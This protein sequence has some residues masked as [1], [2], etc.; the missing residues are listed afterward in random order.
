MATSITEV[1]LRFT[2]DPRGAKEALG[3]IRSELSKSAKE[4][5]ATSKQEAQA[6]AAL[7]RQRSAALIQ[8]WRL[9]TRAL[10]SEEK[11]R[12]QESAREERA[13]AS[14]ALSLQRQRSAALIAQW[15]AEQREQVRIARE[16]AREVEAAQSRRGAFV[17]GAIGGVTALVGVSAVNEIRQAGA[18]WL[19]YSSKLQTTKIAFT[20]MLGSAQLAEDHL[21]E[22]QQ[23][24]LKT[25]F[26]FGELIDASQR[27]Q[28]LGFNAQ[29]VVPILT[30]VGNA[31][32]AAGGGSERLDR[33]VLALSQIQSKGKVAT[34]ELNQ[35]AESGIPAFRIL[36]ET[37]GKTG[38]EVRK[39][40]EEG[41]IS[42]KVFLDAFQKFSQQN[43]GGLMEEQS[44]TFS[45]AMSN[46]KDALLQTSATAFAPL[47][48]KL[49]QTAKGFAD[50][51]TSSKDFQEKLKVV[52]SVATTIFDGLVAVIRAV[53]DA[54]RLMVAAIS[55]QFTLFIESARAVGHTLAAVFFNAMAAGRALRGDLKGAA[56]A[57]RIAQ[58][59]L[60]L[61]ADSAK[62]AFESQG[63]VL[64]TLSGIYR[65]AEARAKALANA[66]AKV[67]GEPVIGAGILRKK[68]TDTED[69]LT[70]K[71]KGSDPAQAAKRI[72]EIQ[73]RAVLDGIQLEEENIERSLKRKEAEYERYVIQIEELE[74]RRHLLVLNG[75]QE[76]AA[77][78][79]RLRDVNARRVALAE[80]E[81][82]REQE[83]N[84]H[85]SEL[86][87]LK[88]KTFEREKQIQ[89]A[90]AKFRADQVEQLRQVLKGN[91]TLLDETDDFIVTY[92]KMGGVLDE[93]QKKWLR[94]DAI[95][96]E[97]RKHME[98]LAESMRA[99]TEEGLGPPEITFP[100][101]TPEQIAAGAGATANAGAGI[102]PPAV[103]D[104]SR[105]A[106]EQ[107]FDAIDENLT[108]KTH[109]AALAGLQAMT[110]A[111]AGLSQAVGEVVESFVLYGAAGLSV[112]KVTAQ[113]LAG[114]ARQAAT[115]A[116]FELAEG[117][118]A[119]A[120]AFFG[121]P[122]AGPSATAH[123]TA[124]AIYGSIA[125]IAAAA[126][127]VVAGNSFSK[128]ATGGAGAFSGGSTRSG[129][130][131]ATPTGSPKTVEF[132]RATQNQQA[133][134]LLVNVKQ[135][136]GHNVQVILDDHRN[137]G[138]IRQMILSE[139]K[140]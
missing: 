40:V 135:E 128:S 10:A 131:T 25:P 88:D 68:A 138:P 50:A 13:R 57:Q 120:L 51:A 85:Q 62:K 89:E 129:G 119:L 16:A 127:R 102:P 111:F 132:D 15:K 5:T 139:I 29:Q 72:A 52:G 6:A 112:Q 28:A 1:V 56:Q 39:L 133:I 18:A 63:E 73:L 130:A 58:Q 8:Q 79:E 126:G 23:F 122:N 113:I 66:Q 95:L 82:R 53:K 36:Q 109:T 31:V 136:P 24:A 22:L 117:F 38:A 14:A 80:I 103:I 97:S 19:D 105:S 123:F 106:I 137:N 33:V 98:E 78:A 90:L 81:A 74:N 93:N 83:S 59:E 54:I 30:D 134:T 70:K 67:G 42:S 114:V 41:Q 100:A 87:K 11:K 26:Q 17:S 69:D 60:K 140:G 55:S 2:G 71:T 45:G 124:A 4:Q 3:Q 101:L 27:M 77:A 91:K 86:N 110:E 47:F 21:K 37:L 20:T 118:A 12:T 61:A 76:E 44:R 99:A 94:F 116:I 107:L 35:L 9:D 46:I 34:Q 84:K 49:S 43:F 121:M 96:I 75:L 115:K 65:D 104:G 108:G 48:E 7:Q 125:G 64:R 92:E 32:A